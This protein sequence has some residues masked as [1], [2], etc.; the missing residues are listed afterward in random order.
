MGLL[1]IH[2]AGHHGDPDDPRGRA[3]IDRVISSYTPTIGALRHARRPATLA[4]SQQATPPALIVAMPTTPGLPYGGELR[5]VPEEVRILNSRLPGS[6]A[7]IE[8]EVADR[9]A[10]AGAASGQETAPTRANVLTHLAVCPIAHFACHGVNDPAD[11]SR[12]RLLLEDHSQAPL[13][14]SALGSLHLSHARLAYLSACDTALSA[15]TQLI[16]EAIH[17]ASGF[18]LA[19]YPHVIGTLWAID[20]RIAVTIADAFYAAFTNE[21]DS[22]ATAL[23]EAVRA[24][25]TDLCATPSLWASHIH[26]G[27]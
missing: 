7:L 5:F 27:A 26:V 19:G 17:L 13:T 1:P 14:V 23:H 8:P 11:P 6:V 4:D 12:S 24:A 9:D 22:A 25:R 18:Q 15:S 3:V 10:T 20:D 21:P 2:A 16:D